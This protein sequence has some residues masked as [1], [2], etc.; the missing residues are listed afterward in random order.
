MLWQCI[1]WCLFS[2]EY[3]FIQSTIN[4][5]T[6]PLICGVHHAYIDFCT[7]KY[8]VVVVCILIFFF[9]FFD[10]SNS[11]PYIYL[12]M[13]HNDLSVIVVI[14]DSDSD[15]VDVCIK[16]FTWFDSSALQTK[17]AIKTGDGSFVSSISLTDHKSTN[18]AWSN[19]FTIFFFVWRGSGVLDHHPQWAKLSK[20]RNL[21]W[22]IQHTNI[23]NKL[24]IA[25][26]KTMK[27]EKIR[28]K[29]MPKV[30]SMFC[31]F[32]VFHLTLLLY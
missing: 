27:R 29:K 22:W 16:V 30:N 6:T 1:N 25:K 20:W 2:C 26:N 15:C 31:L 11:D 19:W 32:A 12:C 8:F 28:R 4:T 9:S 14:T 21:L 23:R 10:C 13:L 17:D 3:I 18:Y 5:N 24:M 7:K